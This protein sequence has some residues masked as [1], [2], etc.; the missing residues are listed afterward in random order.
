MAVILFSV[1]FFFLWLSLLDIPHGILVGVDANSDLVFINCNS[2][3]SQYCFSSNIN[4]SPVH[5]IMESFFAAMKVFWGVLLLGA[6]RRY[7]WVRIIRTTNTA[8]L[9]WLYNVVLDAF[10]VAVTVAVADVNIVVIVVVAVAV[11]VL[12]K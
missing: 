6:L 12:N 9:Q 11:A 4:G 7:P 8:L 2:I 10:T 5:W 3:T 1:V